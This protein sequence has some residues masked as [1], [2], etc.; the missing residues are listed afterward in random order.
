MNLM[1]FGILILAVLMFAI[2]A[3]L[4]V[5][6]RYN[7]GSSAA[8]VA[9][10]APVV[11]PVIPEAA[12]VKVKKKVRA[13]ITAQTPVIVNEP[14]APKKKRISRLQEPGEALGGGRRARREVE[15]QK[16]KAQQKAL[17]SP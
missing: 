12:P 1:K 9:Q 14:A 4:F 5:A 15:A 13:V 11:S 2:L 3:T 17:L 8:Q 7:G 16:L 10:A 6:H